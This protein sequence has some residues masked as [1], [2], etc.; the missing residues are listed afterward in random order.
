MS[1]Y[2][3]MSHLQGQDGRIRD[4][5]LEQKVNKLEALSLCCLRYCLLVVVTIVQHSWCYRDPRPVS[6]YTC[7]N[8]F[9]HKKTLLGCRK[10]IVKKDRDG[11]GE[12]VNI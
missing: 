10:A 12:G 7:L 5:F 1:Q 3:E 2:T 11:K 9:H 6:T 8:C 4:N